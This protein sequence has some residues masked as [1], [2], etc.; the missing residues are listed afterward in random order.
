MTDRCR[1]ESVLK[2]RNLQ[3]YFCTSVE[4]VIARQRVNVDPHATHYVVNLLTLFSRS[5]EFYEDD[6]ECRGTRPLALMLADAVDAETTEKR[7]YV[8]QRIGD[9]ALFTAGF[10]ADGLATRAV[11]VDYYIQMGG[12]AYSSLSEEMRGSFRAKTF[13]PVYRELAI[14]F[15]LL[16]DVLNEVS[17]GARES[18]DVDLLRTYE[19]WLKTGSR[20]AQKILRKNGVVPIGHGSGAKRH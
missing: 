14:N 15:P 12:S 5:E 4:D 18:C 16:V 19:V 6:G 17:E 20:R 3:D 9:V 11:D 13:A 2:V 8:L 10:F 1:R 7:T